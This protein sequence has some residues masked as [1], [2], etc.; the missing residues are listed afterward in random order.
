MSVAAKL[1]AKSEGRIDYLSAN[2]FEFTQILRELEKAPEQAMFGQLIFPERASGR[3]PLVICC[4]GSLGWRGHHHE[5]MVRYLEMGIAVFRVHSFD[6]RQVV[7]VVEDQMQVTMASMIVDSYR[8]L[9]LLV[10]HPRI[11]PARIGITGWSLGGSVALYGAW[12][13][14]AERLAPGG[15]RF[16]AHLPLYPAA[17]VRPEEARW[18]RA[19][20]RVLIGGAD[21]YTPAWFA[22]DLAGELRPAGVDIEVT[23]YPGAQHSFDSIEPSAFLPLAI[24]LGKKTTTVAR[25]GSMFVTGSDGRRHPVDE[26]RHREASFA[27]MKARGAHIGGSW[28]ARRRA[29][30][31]ATAFF[32]EHLLGA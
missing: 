1:G 26:P 28:D 32:G 27:A 5:Y 24:G 23:V 7:S 3:V 22:T 2:P 17:H 14:L 31:D 18:T 6:A 13:P 12:Q 4:H 20:I 9:E 16:A 15:E 25:D 19:P 30:P 21:D 8:A 11:D 10:T 29:F